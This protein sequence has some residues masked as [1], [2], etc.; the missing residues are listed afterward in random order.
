MDSLVNGV[1]AMVRLDVEDRKISNLSLRVAAMNVQEL[2]GFL[3]KRGAD[4]ARCE[5]QRRL[6]RAER[7]CGHWWRE[8]W[9]VIQDGHDHKRQQWF[10]RGTHRVCDIWHIR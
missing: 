9:S 5:E 4:A 2:L 7:R 8:W 6:Q 3:G 1:M 10:C